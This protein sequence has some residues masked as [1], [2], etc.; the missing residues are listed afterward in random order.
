ML[1]AIGLLPAALQGIDTMNLLSVTCG[2]DKVTRI[3]SVKANPTLLLSFDW[4]VSDN[5]NACKNITILLRIN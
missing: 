2:F 5:D 3:R 4:Y 1:S